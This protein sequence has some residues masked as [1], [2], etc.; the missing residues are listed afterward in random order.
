MTNASYPA[1]SASLEHCGSSARRS[2][3]PSVDGK[4]A[5]PHAQAA[6]PVLAILEGEQR[7]TGVILSAGPLNDKLS[8]QQYATVKGYRSFVNLA[9][10]KAV[11]VMEAS[12][13]D[14]VASWFKKVC[15]R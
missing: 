2:G 5:I 11:C 10:G 13:A 1:R 6:Y 12:N 7:Q 4:D 3:I 15:R 8:R 9:E 14:Q